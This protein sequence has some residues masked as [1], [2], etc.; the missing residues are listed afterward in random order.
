MPCTKPISANSGIPAGSF[1]GH[2]WRTTTWNSWRRYTLTQKV[3][4]AR[5][6]SS[7]VMM[8]GGVLRVLRGTHGKQRV[9][10]AQSKHN[11]L[12][13]ALPHSVPTSHWSRKNYI[14]ITLPSL[15]QFPT[16]SLCY[17]NTTNQ[18]CNLH[19]LVVQYS[20]SKI[21]FSLI[22]ICVAASQRIPTNR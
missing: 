16:A 17:P 11:T 2:S 20:V 7:G 3:R 15:L 19:V 1:K 5:R 12:C 13:Q 4:A 9:Y 21:Q 10:A 14:H 22:V 18:H 8:D 6:S